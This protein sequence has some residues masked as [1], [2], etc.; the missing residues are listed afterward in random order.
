MVSA[1][2]S[3]SGKTVFTCGLLA[4]LVA[5]GVDVAAFKCG[6]DYIDPAFH[7][8]VLGVPSRNLDLFLQGEAGVTRT[9]TRQGAE[10]AVIEGAMGYYDGVAGTDEASAWRIAC[11]A[12]AACVLVVR[13]RGASTTLAAQLAGL[14]AFR[15]PSRIAGVV[16]TDCKP[17]LYT[18]LKGVVEREC[19][20]AVLGYLPPMEE[21][22]L[23]S[24]HLG[25]LQAEEVANL[26]GRIRAVGAQVE[27]TVDVDGLLALATAKGGFADDSEAPGEDVAP[28][29]VVAVARD[30][31]FSF[32]YQDSLDALEEAGARLAFFSPLADAALPPDAD[33]LYLGGGYPE[34]H[35]R[36][37]AGNAAMR[38]AVRGAVRGGMPCVA[39]CGGFLYLQGSLEDEGGR[40]W[41][42]AGVWPASRAYRTE[43][44]RRF[45]YLRMSSDADT[46]L[47]HAG[48]GVPAH[49]F[50]HWDC[51]DC[52][53]DL[54]ACKPSG[55]TWRFGHAGPT[56]Y[57][58][59]PHV[60]LAGEVPLARRFVEAAQR[61]R[62]GRLRGE[63]GD[64]R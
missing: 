45:G 34:L 40:P 56:L 48:E 22:R 41:P 25:L 32:Y 10:V 54:T 33:A 7:R 16:F 55:R 13:P 17:S 9:L 29:C 28:R 26:A 47:V 60:H 27:R 52:G 18:L 64:A 49:E 63:K 12:G 21:A 4:A 58:G 31:A 20:L 8:R 14:R 2:S 6:P 46:L 53:A 3:D 61:Y 57:A 35:A 42:M 50:H 44:L 37:L 11:V 5:R 23:A 43:G 36:E 24:R 30:A 62:A 15:R 1:L 19:S 38:D 51:T 39:E 59:F